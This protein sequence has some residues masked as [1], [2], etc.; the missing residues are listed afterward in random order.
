MK[1][2]TMP[3]KQ[4]SNHQCRLATRQGLRTAAMASVAMASVFALGCS[5][6]LT[7]LIVVV[8]SDLAVPGEL[9]RV[10]LE[11]TGPSGDKALQDAA[12]DLATGGAPTLPLTLSLTPG[13]G[14]LEPVTVTAV[15]TGLAG[16]V[17]RTVVTGFV[18]GER[19]VV[20][21]W[22]LRACLGVE[23]TTGETCGDG[24]IC[25]DA[26][27]PPDDLPPWTG[28]PPGI[29]GGTIMDAAADAAIDAGTDAPVGT[30]AG[31]EI[32][33]DTLDDWYD[34]GETSACCNGSVVCSACQEQRYREHFCS[35][36]TCSFNVTSSR[37]VHGG[38][39][40]D[41][42][43]RAPECGDWGDCNACPSG[44][45]TRPCYDWQ[46]SAGA[47]QM[48]QQARFETDDCFNNCSSDTQQGLC[49]PENQCGWCHPSCIQCSAP[50]SGDGCEALCIL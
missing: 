4:R 43:T 32:G 26:T 16:V 33:C 18:R 48:L 47:C 37:I 21:L 13:S 14:A 2:F 1:Q 50:G 7:E 44:Q 36:S 23:C 38:C 22:L 5:S 28:T 39:G 41:C 17:E 45:Q 10:T 35:G 25:V 29:D 9:Q 6:G 8:D 40:E 3:P 46:C 31:C 34:H 30:D 20:R 42:T 19:R 24:G 49:C 11:V 27:V 15:G 12:V